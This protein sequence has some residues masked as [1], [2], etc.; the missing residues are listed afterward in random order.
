MGSGWIPDGA[1]MTNPHFK[2]Q[3][4]RMIARFGYRT[5][6]AAVCPMTVAGRRCQ[7]GKTGQCVCLKWSGTKMLDHARV[8]LDSYGKHV[9]TA[10]PYHVDDA[11]LDRFKNDMADLGLAVSIEDWSAW[12]PGNCRLVTVR[13]DI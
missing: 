13:L 12:N 11:D 10:E 7:A 5:S 2:A 1:E 8:W 3:T 9:L 6:K 4:D